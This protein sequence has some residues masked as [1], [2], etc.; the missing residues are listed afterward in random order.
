MMVLLNAADADGAADGA[1][2]A[3][4]D[5][6]AEIAA[7]AP[8]AGDGMHM[9]KEGMTVFPPVL[10]TSTNTHQN[11]PDFSRCTCWPPQTLQR[12]YSAL[13]AGRP[14]GQAFAAV[15]EYL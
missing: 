5:G 3:G 9:P 13:P 14:R 10:A 6:A 15:H 8:D 12:E 1:D 11:P 7:D 4:A 2:A